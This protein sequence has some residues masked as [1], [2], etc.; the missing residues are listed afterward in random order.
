MAPIIRYLYT[1]LKV[2]SLNWLILPKT[3]DITAKIQQCR[4]ACAPPETQEQTLKAPWPGGWLA[5]SRDRN[6][7]RKCATVSAPAIHSYRLGDPTTLLFSSDRVTWPMHECSNE[8]SSFGVSGNPLC[9]KL[10]TWN[11]EMKSSYS[12]SCV[13]LNQNCVFFLSFFFLNWYR[14]LNSQP[15]SCMQALM[16]LS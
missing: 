8:K 9:P 13:L 3:G 10:S 12:T 15:R 4:D 11:V 5:G 7:S 2:L 14:E 6:Q 1:F 16:L